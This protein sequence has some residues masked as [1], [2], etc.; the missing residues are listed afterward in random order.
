MPS[1]K[2]VYVFFGF[3]RK[4][5]HTKIQQSIDKDS[6]HNGYTVFLRVSTVGDNFVSYPLSYII[7][8]PHNFHQL[9]FSPPHLSLTD[10]A[11]LPTQAGIRNIKA[12]YPLTSDEDLSTT[13]PLLWTPRF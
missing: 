1:A 4:L 5:G 8:L 2:I 9:P 6:V 10:Y 3:C 12:V 11:D 7:L 13:D